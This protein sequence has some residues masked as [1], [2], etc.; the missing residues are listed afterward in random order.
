LAWGRECPWL[1]GSRRPE[2]GRRGISLRR[3]GKS[4]RRRCK[5]LRRRCKSLGWGSKS[6]GWGSKALR[7]WG[8]ATWRR[9][10]RLI[11][12]SQEEEDTSQIPPLFT[13]RQ[14]K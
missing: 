4:L 14:Q 1:T 2:G 11:G 10:S 12:E 6:L 8:K 13:F 5:S 9:R 7:R 3:R